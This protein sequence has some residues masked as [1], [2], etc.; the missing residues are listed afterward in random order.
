MTFIISAD[1]FREALTQEKAVQAAL[2]KLIQ[3]LTQL[4]FSELTKHKGIHLEKLKD[5]ADPKSGEPLYSL[6]VTLAVRALAMVPNGNL[7]LLAVRPDHDKGVP[8]ALAPLLRHLAEDA[9]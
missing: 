5:L 9:K 1:F 6:R 3:S 7:V 4:S 2:G 8:Q